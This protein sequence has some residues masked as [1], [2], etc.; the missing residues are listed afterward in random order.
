MSKSCRN[1]IARLPIHLRTAPNI[2]NLVQIVANPNPQPSRQ[3]RDCGISFYHYYVQRDIHGSLKCRNIHP[4]ASGQPHYWLADGCSCRFPFHSH[5]V[6]CKAS[7]VFLRS[8]TAAS[9]WRPFQ[10]G[11][12]D[13]VECNYCGALHWKAPFNPIHAS[14]SVAKWVISFAGPDTHVPKPPP[15][16]HRLS[17]NCFRKHIQQ[18]NSVLLA[19]NCQL[20]SRISPRS[21]PGPA[22]AMCLYLRNS[23][24]RL[25]V[26]L[27]EFRHV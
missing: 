3:R 11:R 14:P 20:L 22:I 7:V 18:F 10:L 19:V 24:L 13:I 26:L 21:F 17:G 15:L 12:I 23:W 2:V 25:D 27:D 1:V 9:R 8:W 16:L 5:A 4:L 6:I